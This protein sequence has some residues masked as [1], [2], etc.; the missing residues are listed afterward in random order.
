VTDPAGTPPLAD[1]GEI[2][3]D[4]VSTRVPGGCSTVMVA[5]VN[6]RSVIVSV[7]WV[8]GQP[9]APGITVGGAT[10]TTLKGVLP[11]LIS[12]AGIAWLPVTVMGAGF[13]P[14]AWFALPGLEHVAVTS[15]VAVR[16][17]STSPLPKP[18]NSPAA[19]SDSPSSVNVGSAFLPP[20]KCTLDADAVVADSRTPAA[21][22]AATMSDRRI[23]SASRLGDPL[24]Q[25][26][27]RH[28]SA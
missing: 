24:G 28:Y 22:M 25:A 17:T 9:G 18:L 13:W 23:V 21:T 7:H 19:R 6:A 1:A 20:F 15:A 16:V 4:T 26:S 12:D 27:A 2:V 5:L 11:F 10:V 14:G 3:H 8:L